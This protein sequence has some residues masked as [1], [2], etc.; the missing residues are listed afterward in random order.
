MKKTIVYLLCALCLACLSLPTNTEASVRHS[1]KKKLLRHVVIFKFKDT[2]SAADVK[3]VED[4]FRALPSKIKEIKDFEWGKNNSPEGLN[5]GFT[6]CF[7]V[8]FASEKDRETYLP[9]PD[10]KAFVEVLKPYL[11]KALVIDYWAEK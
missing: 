7:F 2:A 5:Q 1:P 11:E 8:S 4:A 10:H 3:K 6:H 9:H